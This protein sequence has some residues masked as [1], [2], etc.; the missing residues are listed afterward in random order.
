MTY[1]TTV[2][3][4]SPLVYYRMDDTESVGKETK[5]EGSLKQNGTVNGTIPAVAGALVPSGDLDKAAG[6]SNNNANFVS[7]ANSAGLEAL[8]TA[9]TFEMW[10]FPLAAGAASKAVLQKTNATE[11]ENEGVSILVAESG[12]ALQATTFFTVVKETFILAKSLT[13]SAW[14]YIVYT[15]DNAVFRWYI[16]AAQVREKAFVGPT[17]A[18]AGPTKIGSRFANVAQPLNGNVD[19]VAIYS[20]ALSQARISAHYFVGTQPPEPVVAA[21]GAMP[22]AGHKHPAI[23]IGALA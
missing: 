17:P 23:R 3:E 18:F 10:V 6:F 22:R 8:T 16:N 15:Y 9:F 14:N 20:T 13:V 19:E 2:L 21:S 7:I 12:K 1:V 11:E 5:D 4:D